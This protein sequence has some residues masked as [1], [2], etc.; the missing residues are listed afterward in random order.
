MVKVAKNL[1]TKGFKIL[2]GPTE[3]GRGKGKA[4]KRLEA[5]DKGTCIKEPEL[6]EQ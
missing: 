4:K 3:K 1:K 5:K 6:N 2:R